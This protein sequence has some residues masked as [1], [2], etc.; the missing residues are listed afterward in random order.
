MDKTVAELNI[1][2]LKK[3]LATESGPV[4]RQIIQQ[5]LVDEVTRLAA[6]QATHS[7][8]VPAKS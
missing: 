2:H 8:Q 7:R 5:S 6:A 4:K 1:E 3:L